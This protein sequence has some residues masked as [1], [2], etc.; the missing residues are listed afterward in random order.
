MSYLQNTIINIQNWLPRIKRVKVL[1]FHTYN[2]YKNNIYVTTIIDSYE[3]KV[4]NNVHLFKKNVLKKQ[5]KQ[6][7]M[8]VGVNSI[9]FPKKQFINP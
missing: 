4:Q 5:K 8:W 3:T 7:E 6:I 2:E 9:A 1:N